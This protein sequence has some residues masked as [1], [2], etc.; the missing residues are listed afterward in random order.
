MF[1][2]FPKPIPGSI[3]IF[4]SDKSLIL[5]QKVYN[6]EVRYYILDYFASCLASREVELLLE[7]FF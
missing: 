3:I 2:S 4:L 1:Q 5:Y 7:I 6:Q